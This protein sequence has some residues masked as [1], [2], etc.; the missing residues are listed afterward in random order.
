MFNNSNHLLSQN[1]INTKEKSST[2]EKTSF[3]EI[4]DR[5]QI[6]ADI[7]KILNSFDDQCS[8]VAYKKGIYIY[9]S[10]GSGKTHFAVDVLKDL[11][12]DVIKYDA[13]DVRNKALI[14]TI[15]SNNVSNRN[16]LD[17]MKGRTKKIAI[18]MDEIDGMNNG[19]KG[20][21]TALIKLIRQKKTKKQKLENLTM[22]PIIC[23]GNYYV[24]KKIKELIKVCHSFELKTPT[25]PQMSRLLDTIVGPTNISVLDKHRPQ[26]LDHIQGDMRKMMFI[27]DLYKTKPHLLNENTL[28]NIFQI[29]S[30]NEDS[31]KI[32]AS[33]INQ[34]ASFQDHNI[35]MNDNDRTIVALLWHENVADVLDQMPNSK[36]MP[37]YSTILDNMCFADYIDRITFQN[38]IW[39][40]NE[41]SSLMKTFYNNRLYHDA[42]PENRGKY[43]PV[44]VRFTK[45][46]TKYSTEYNNSLFIYNMCQELNMDKKDVIAF[47]QEMRLLFG[48][49]DFMQ[50]PENANQI[51]NMFENYNVSK[52]DIRRMYRY[53]DKNSKKDAGVVLEDDDD[54]G[55]D[56]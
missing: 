44:E 23:I 5:T 42:F 35:I 11:G 43:K 13:G 28:Q 7:K 54:N 31:K 46:L 26:I 27:C 45:V 51:E 16:V 30:F 49:G 36:S 38:Q 56:D 14:D 19:D 48:G 1:V 4:L 9:G 41:M 33:L 2:I 29:K 3:S 40:F 20:G 18:V 24:D 12:Y 52:L 17:M 15:T 47:F 21:I 37:F 25:R 53:L 55:S 22:N 50:N 10:P 39:L 8:N 6:V 34:P 32:T